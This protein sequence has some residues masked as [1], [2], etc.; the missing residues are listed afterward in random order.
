MKLWWRN[1]VNKN[2]RECEKIEND[3]G[4]AMR[5]KVQRGKGIQI[6]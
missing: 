6:S 2:A 5:K 3:K 1:V 4:K